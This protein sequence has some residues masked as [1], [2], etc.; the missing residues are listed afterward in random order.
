MFTAQGEVKVKRLLM[1]L[2][3]KADRALLHSP[4]W[5]VKCYFTSK[6]ESERVLRENNI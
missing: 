1:L 3:K 2:T 4:L 5:Y 6:S